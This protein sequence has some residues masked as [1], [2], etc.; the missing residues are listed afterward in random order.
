MSNKKLEELLWGA[1]E[2]LRGQ[3]D[4]S[5]YKQYIFPLLFYKRLSDVYLEEYNEAME[6]HEGD[7]EYAAMPMF[8]R[9]NIPSEAS[10]EKVRNTSKNIG[11]AIQT[12]LRLIEANNPRL[13]GVFGDAQ[14]TNKER[15]PD[16]LLADLIEHFSKIPL[17]IKSVAQDDLGEAYEYLIKKFADDSGHTAAEFYTNQIGRA[18]V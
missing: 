6:L 5:D 2:F 9:F 13:H 4:A 8:H 12:A 1:A 16:H 15:L 3:I 18:H 11:E 7:A 10:W 17:G 14:W